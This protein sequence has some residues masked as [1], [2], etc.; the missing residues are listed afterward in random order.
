MF[1][2]IVATTVAAVLIF[3]TLATLSAPAFVNGLTVPGAT[4]DATQAP[5]ANEG[6]LGFFSDIYYDPK[7]KQWWALS[8]RGPGGGVLSYQTRVQRFKI[9]INRK[10]VDPILI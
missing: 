5:A 9:K 1:R 6:R 4:V 8:D 7:R 10:S 3:H 2:T